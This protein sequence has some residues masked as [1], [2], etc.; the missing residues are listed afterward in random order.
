MRIKI[1]FV[2]LICFLISSCSTIRVQS[3]YDH[4]YNFR[5]YGSYRVASDSELNLRDALKR[6][7]LVYKR[8]L[9]AINKDLQAK[10]FIL[11][12]TGQADFV[13]VAHAGVK[14]KMRLEQYNAAGYGWYHPWWGPYGGYTNISYYKE[15]TLVLD[16]VDFKNKE[17]AWRGTGTD[18]IRNYSSG[19]DMQKDIDDAVTKILANFPPGSDN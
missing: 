4:S 15:G 12:R 17:L 9:D 14:E 2:P 16:I 3:D 8:V 18:V 5:Q 1:F 19:N 7:P 6:N 11:K 13:V 10:G